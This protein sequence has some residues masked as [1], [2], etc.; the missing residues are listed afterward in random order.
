MKNWLWVAFLLACVPAAAEADSYLRDLTDKP[1]AYVATS[2]KWTINPVPVCWEAL[3]PQ[4]QAEREAVKAA[5]E[6]TWSAHS[7]LRFSGWQKCAATNSGVRIGLDDSAANAPHTKGLGNKLNG[8]R[9]GMVLN[10]T[11]EKWGTDCRGAARQACIYNIAVH[12]FGHAIGFAHEQN[13]PDT[14][15]E[16]LKKQG[17]QGPNGDKVLTPWDEHS[18]MNYCNAVYVND[19]KLSDGDIRGVQC[20][21]DGI[22]CKVDSKGVSQ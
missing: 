20:L 12:E 2:S 16:C 4:F 9:N 3:D 18:V 13:R 10:F 21:Y 6:A 11:F 7:K 15:G 8:V 5:I 14:P 22:V 1:F 17:P 19:G